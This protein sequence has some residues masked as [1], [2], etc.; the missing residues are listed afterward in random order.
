MKLYGLIGKTLKHSFSQTYFTAKFEREGITDC[1]Y[2]N[3][4]LS[5]IEELPRMLAEHPELRGFNITIPYKE[6][7]LP[8]LHARN[9]VVAATGACNCVR[10][11]EGKL[12]GFNTDVIGFGQSLDRDRK[13]A[14]NRALVLGTGGAAKAVWYAL[15]QRSIP[16]TV[17][18][19]KKQADTLTYDDLDAGT[20]AR[21]PLII[22]TTPLGMFPD[23]DSFPPL[24]YEALTAGHYLYDLVYNPEQTVFLSRGAERGAVTRNG[25]EM[26]LLQA[27]ESW[28]IWNL[29]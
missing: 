2:R 5:S 4:E 6:D 7:V 19:R 13:A 29:P 18:S 11:I 28:R 27:E 10:I 9:E 23:T 26:L 22:N 14:H 15:E 20:I 1:G 17:V 24:P 12:H 21:H 3:F 25:Y 16:F 8:Y